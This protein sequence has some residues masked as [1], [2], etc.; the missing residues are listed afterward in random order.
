[1]KVKPLDA[2]VLVSDMPAHGLRAG[3]L[4]TVVE[5]LAGDAVEAEFL[6]ASGETQAVVTLPLRDL[7]PAAHDDVIAVRRA[8]KHI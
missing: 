8:S 6:R 1:M 2:V 3:E 4:G 5:V 7:R